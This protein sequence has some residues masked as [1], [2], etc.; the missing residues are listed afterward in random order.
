[1]L[2]VALCLWDLLG[3]GLVVMGSEAFAL[4]GG[5]HADFVS[6]SVAI[7]T[8]QLDPPCP[9]VRRDAA[10]V[11]CAAPPPLAA[12]NGVWHEVCWH[13]L[14]RTHQLLN[15]FGTAARSVGDVTGGTQLP[16]AHL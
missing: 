5:D 7:R 13:A 4:A 1:M 10:V 15:R 6:P 8:L 2:L 14:A 9:K 11:R 16:A 3:H 12:A